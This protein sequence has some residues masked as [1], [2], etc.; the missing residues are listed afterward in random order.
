MAIKST[1]QAGHELAIIRL[2]TKATRPPNKISQ[3]MEKIEKD[4]MPFYISSV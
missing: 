1:C 2:I 3:K 4:E